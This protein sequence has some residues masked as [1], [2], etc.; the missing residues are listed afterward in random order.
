MTLRVVPESLAG[1]SA[2]IEAVTARLAAAHAAA[3]VYRG[4]HPAW[5]RLGFGVQHR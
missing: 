1:A 4:G 5:V 2:A 3:A